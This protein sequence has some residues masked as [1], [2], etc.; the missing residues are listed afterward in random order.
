MLV[1][2]QYS[3]LI[4]SNSESIIQHSSNQCDMIYKVV[5]VESETLFYTKVLDTLR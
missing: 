2:L 3:K 4:H 5:K 1:L